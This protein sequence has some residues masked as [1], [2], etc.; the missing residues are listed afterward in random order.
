VTALDV[1][2]AKRVDVA[3]DEADEAGAGMNAG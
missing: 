2:L 1:R 3:I